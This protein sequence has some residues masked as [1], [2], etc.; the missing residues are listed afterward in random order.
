MQN[1]DIVI[2]AWKLTSAEV[3]QRYIYGI[4]LTGRKWCVELFNEENGICQMWEKTARE[5]QR[6]KLDREQNIIECAE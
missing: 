2:W 1:A 5:E 6:Q 3:E 4:E